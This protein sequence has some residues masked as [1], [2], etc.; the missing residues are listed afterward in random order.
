MHRKRGPQRSC[1]SQAQVSLQGVVPCQQLSSKNR[2]EERSGHLSVTVVELNNRLFTSA[3][4]R[5][6]ILG[7]PRHPLRVRSRPG[8]R[9]AIPKQSEVVVVVDGVFDVQR[10]V[11]PTSV[12]V[13]T[14]T[15]SWYVT[16]AACERRGA[17]LLLDCDMET[18]ECYAAV[19]AIVPLAWTP[20]S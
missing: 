1:V 17:A 13:P 10:A 2:A 15:S 5:R 20:S 8:R 19:V 18:L 12:V 3:G 7:S 16:C 4:G 6:P 11:P 9:P 14:R